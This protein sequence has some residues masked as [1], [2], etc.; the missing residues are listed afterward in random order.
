MR[1]VRRDGM[2]ASCMLLWYGAAV[3]GRHRCMCGKQSGITSE[4]DSE[5]THAQRSFVCAY[6][7]KFLCAH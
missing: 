5:V 3:V 1:H 6:V 7:I 4:V 2:A